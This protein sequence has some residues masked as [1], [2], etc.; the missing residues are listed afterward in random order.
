LNKN[1]KKALFSFLSIYIGSGILLVSVM[2]Y[3][4]YNN[5][6]RVIADTCDMELSNASMHIKEQIMDAYMNKKKFNP[7]KL[8]NKD[9]SFA[10]YD[11]NKKEIYSYL[12]ED[13]NFD[14]QKG[15]A[16]ES[17]H[18]Y[19]IIT[20]DKDD[21]PIK[22]I[23]VETCQ[24]VYAK[25][26][27]K[28]YVLI[29]LVLSSVFIGFIAYFL[30]KIL[31]NPVR[32]K[33]EHMDKFIK[34]SAHELNTPVAV[35]M[36]SIS[37]L[38]KG[39]NPEK[40]MRYILS[41][42]KQISQIYNDIHFSAFNEINDDVHEE[43]NLKE[44]VS[45][46]V[47]YF[48]D[49]SLTKNITIKSDLDDCKILMDKTKTQKLVNN[50]ISNAIKYSNSNSQIEVSLKNN[51]FCVKDYGIGID[52]KEQKDIFKRYKRGNNIEGGFGIGLDI[53]KRICSEYELVPSLESKL[54]EGSVFYIDFSTITAGAK[55]NIHKN[56][57]LK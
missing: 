29:A 54:D 8:G 52:E 42:S 1:E 4:Y 51:I 24:G 6:V 18:L 2:L 55:C 19:R 14:F 15:I 56:D 17:G 26:N 16:E 10:L 53:V 25:N 50:L 31:L 12:H 27:L 47:G 37:M 30:A 41:S 7:K 36:T 9:M 28:I 49:I 39:K 45:E 23:I 11:K 57:N 40:M 22:Y 34:D 38:K 20:L 46:S 21:I 5:E 43:F 3:I 35:L 33:V 13:D 48:N 44:L 32:E